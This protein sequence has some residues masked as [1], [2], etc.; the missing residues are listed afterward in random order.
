M[1]IF[2]MYDKKAAAHHMPF[3]FHQKNE[4]LR[5]LQ[6]DVNNNDGMY[7][8]FPADFSIWILGEFDEL[9]GKITAYE[10]PEFLEEC[11]NLITRPVE[12]K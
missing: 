10:K 2:A 12:T 1:R 3:Y 11:V 6:N 7:K 4:A 5:A 8:K 9:T